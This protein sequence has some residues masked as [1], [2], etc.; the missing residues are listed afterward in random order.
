MHVPRR[1]VALLDGVEEIANGIVGVGAGELVGLL[2]RQVLDAL[3]GLEVELAVVSFALLVGEL[4]GVRAVAVHESVAIRG[5][6]VAEQEHDLVR[7]LRSQR[8]EVPEHVGVFQMRLRVAF[9]GV[10]EAREEDRV[11]N[12]EDRRVVADDVPDAIISVEFDCKASG[13]TSSVSAAAF[14]AWN[15]A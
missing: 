12:E 3:S 8:D 13:I 14:T 7:G 10:D 11:T 5:A 9:L 4:E 6:A 2:G 1:E 15:D